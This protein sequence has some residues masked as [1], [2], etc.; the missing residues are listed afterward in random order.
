[1]SISLAGR[2]TFSFIRSMRLVPPAMN[3][4][5]GFCA[6]WLDGVTHVARFD[7]VEVDHGVDP[8]GAPCMTSSMAATMFG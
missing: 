8:G 7:I 5:A 2:A 1:M 3:F 4:A 6:I